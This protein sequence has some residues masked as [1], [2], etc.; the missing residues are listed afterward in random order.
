MKGYGGIL[1]GVGLLE[2]LDRI[3]GDALGLARRVVLNG[4]A[5]FT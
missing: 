3:D 2:D 1:K 4:R 5:C